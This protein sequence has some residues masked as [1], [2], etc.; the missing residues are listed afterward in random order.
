MDTPQYRPLTADD[1]NFRE[2]DELQGTD[3]AWVRA[4]VTDSPIWHLLG[5]GK[6][7][8]GTYFAARRPLKEVEAAP[9]T[10]THADPGTPEPGDHHSMTLTNGPLIPADAGQKTIEESFD[11]RLRDEFAMHAIYEASQFVGSEREPD[12]V[13][14]RAYKIADAM[15]KERRPKEPL[16]Q[17]IPF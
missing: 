6:D 16:T 11:R 15:M 1:G 8:V 14:R 17:E 7:H 9:A 12:A 4:Y 3:G 2:G 10:E 5:N 13:A